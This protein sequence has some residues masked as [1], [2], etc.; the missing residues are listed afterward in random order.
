MKGAQVHIE[1]ISELY[2]PQIYIFIDIVISLLVA[3]MDERA[4]PGKGVSFMY[5]PDT[6]I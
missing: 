2:S 6:P 3:Q 4:T 1:L 5:E